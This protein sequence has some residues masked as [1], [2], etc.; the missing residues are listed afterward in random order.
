MTTTAPKPRAAKLPGVPLNCT[1]CGTPLTGGI[2][3]FGGIGETLCFCCHIDTAK[4]ECSD[5]EGN[6]KQ[7]CWNC[8]GS[9]ECSCCDC[10][11]EH[12][13]GDCHGEGYDKHTPCRTCKGE[14]QIVRKPMTA[15]LGSLVTL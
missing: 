10:G 7:K 5:C 9:G 13:C 6:G 14:G 3:T 4:V 11:H 15:P 8:N 2:D 12:E 1:E